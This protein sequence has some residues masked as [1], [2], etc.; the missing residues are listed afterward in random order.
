[1]SQWAWRKDN[2]L[3]WPIE[4]GPISRW[5]IFADFIRI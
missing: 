4:I 2:Q 1:M 3:K 5:P